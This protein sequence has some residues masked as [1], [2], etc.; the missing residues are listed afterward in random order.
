M[1]SLFQYEKKGPTPTLA[2][3]EV[4]D[5]W[6]RWIF[7]KIGEQAGVGEHNACRQTPRIFSGRM[8]KSEEELRSIRM[9][10]RRNEGLV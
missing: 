9:K 5:A 1:D 7:A 6:M 4:A 3:K 10:F 2:Q 8:G